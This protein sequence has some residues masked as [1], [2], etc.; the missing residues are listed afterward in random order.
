MFGLRKTLVSSMRHTNLAVEIRTFGYRVLMFP[1]IVPDLV[2]CLFFFQ[3]LPT[4][5]LHS[6]FGL[7]KTLVS[8]MRHTNLAVD[9]RTIAYRL[10]TFP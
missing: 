1:Q 6:M 9:I 10:L 5:S 7:R 4:R 8:F 3:L 2:L